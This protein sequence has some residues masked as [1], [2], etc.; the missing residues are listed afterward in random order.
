MQFANRTDAG[1]KLAQ[2]I[3]EANHIHNAFVLALPRGGIP[4][5][6]ELSHE[7]QAPFDILLVRKLGVPGH[8]ELAMG[9]LAYGDVLVLNED[10]VRSLRIPHALI[11][12]EIRQE[13]RELMRRNQL[14]RQGREAPDVK[15]KSVILVD[16]GIAT[17]AT[18]RAG[19]IALRKQ[20]PAQIIVAVPVAPKEIHETLTEADRII[21]LATPEPFYGVGMHYND[22]SQVSDEEA[23][24]MLTREHHFA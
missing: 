11:E 22:F 12:E 7:L 24:A 1:R 3:A 2:K 16:D 8:E 21:C 19:I 5:G 13:Q 6:L 20:A 15:D 23:K 18:M 9:A 10:I 14:Y 17:G 4:I